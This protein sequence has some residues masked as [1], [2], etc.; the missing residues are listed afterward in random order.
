MKVRFNEDEYTIM[1]MFER[2][3]RKQTMQEIYNVS[4]FLKEDAEMLA[5]VNST[6]NKMRNISDQ[7]FMEMDLTS[8]Q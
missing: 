4:R 2:E 1:A 3:G 6:L 7:D 8:Y 5:L